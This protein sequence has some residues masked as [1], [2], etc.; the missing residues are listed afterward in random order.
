MIIDNVE[1]PCVTWGTLSVA[2]HLNLHQIRIVL[3]EPAGARN[4]GSVARV[5]KNMGLRQLVLVNP[6]CDPADLE[7]QHMAVHAADLLAAAQQVDSIPAAL[8]GCTQ[9]M[10]TTSRH[11]PLNVDTNTP[12]RLLPQLLSD[13]PQPA[14]ILFGPEDRGLSDAELN[15]AQVFIR[16]PS[17]AA[18]PSL[19]L[20]QAVG[21]CCY[22][23]YQAQQAQDQQ[24]QAQPFPVP[25]LAPSVAAF[26]DLEAYFQHLESVLLQIGYLL[27][28]T[29]ASR[30]AKF[31]RLFN[32]SALSA[33]EVAML[34][35]ILRQVEW[36]LK[37]CINPPS[38]R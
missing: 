4:L 31:R 38:H 5:M 11:T 26:E 8:Q 10:A 30:M 20:A 37:N 27:P 16:I 19:N 23:L 6:H 24:A 36:G 14:A 9:V 18:Y 15:Y 33:Q 35:G 32:R 12:R 17:D 21:I 22:E 2:A 29:Q 25:S 28:H 1:T 13:N 3:V 7:A 34:R